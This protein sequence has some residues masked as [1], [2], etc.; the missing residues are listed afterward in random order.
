MTSV[1]IGV[2]IAQVMIDITEPTGAVC[3]LSQVINSRYLQR[4]KPND[5]HRDSQ[6]FPDLLHSHS[7]CEEGFNLPVLTPRLYSPS[8]TIPCQADRALS[9][10]SPI[11][12]RMSPT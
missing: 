9:A 3:N 11:P 12:C 4:T 8:Q 5:Q 1:R 7:P 2:E 10:F 6:S